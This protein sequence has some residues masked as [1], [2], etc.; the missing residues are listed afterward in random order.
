MTGSTA[1]LRTMRTATMTSD[2]VAE[3]TEATV[4]IFFEKGHISCAYCPLLETYARDQ[5]R[6]TGEYIVDKRFTVGHWCPLNIKEEN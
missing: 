3:Y 1:L 6:R 4:S 2:G 5:C